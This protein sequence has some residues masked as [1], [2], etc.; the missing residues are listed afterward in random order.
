M[1]ETYRRRGTD[2]S[3]VMAATYGS[4][5]KWI[6]DHLFL[7]DAEKDAVKAELIYPVEH[8]FRH[9]ISTFSGTDRYADSTR[10]RDGTLIIKLTYVD[11]KIRK[12]IS[13]VVPAG[14]KIYF[15]I[16]SPFQGDGK[17]RDVVCDGLRRGCLA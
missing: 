10:W 3:I 8:I 14:I 2:D 17:D 12:A 7:P 9:N 5:E 1:I 16:E 4:N 11:D 13:K 15:D 6:A